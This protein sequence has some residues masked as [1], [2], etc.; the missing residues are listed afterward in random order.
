MF[1][2]VAAESDWVAVSPQGP[3]HTQRVRW[4]EG[5]LGVCRSRLGFVKP[6]QAAFVVLLCVFACVSSP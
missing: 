4:A 3:S 5:C 6:P 1:E 2:T